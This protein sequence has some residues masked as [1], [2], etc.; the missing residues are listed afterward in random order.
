VEQ[1]EDIAAALISVALLVVV[2]ATFSSGLLG[3]KLAVLPSRPPLQEFL[4]TY[5]GLDIFV[6]AFI[7]FA[8]A[9]AVA[10]LF[11]V[12]KGPGAVETTYLEP[13]GEKE[14]AAT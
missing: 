10:T 7:V 8:A 6:Q 1:R 3:L 12:E 14:E 4:W 2:L 9:T 13:T 11:R 5:R